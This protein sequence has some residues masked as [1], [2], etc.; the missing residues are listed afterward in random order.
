MTDGRLLASRPRDD[1]TP[2]SS[3][4]AV[5]RCYAYL[6]ERRRLREEKEGGRR[7]APDDAMKGSSN[8]RARPSIHERN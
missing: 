2:E 1:A 4:N 5:G 7:P 6:I 8:D 3:Q